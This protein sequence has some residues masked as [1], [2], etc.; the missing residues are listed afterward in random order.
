M[1]DELCKESMDEYTCARERGRM[2]TF[3]EMNFKEMDTGE[4]EF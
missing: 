2:E 3:W 1:E 4:R